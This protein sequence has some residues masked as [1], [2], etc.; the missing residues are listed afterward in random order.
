MSTQA[1]GTFKVASWTEKPVKETVGD[2]KITRASVI[3]SFEGAIEGE[4][5]VEYVM[6]H[7]ADKS[8]TFAGMLHIEGSI[9]G[10]TGSFV[11]QTTGTF[12]GKAARGTWSVVPGMGSGGLKDLNGMGGFDAPL[13]PD[14]TYTLHYNLS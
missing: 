7:R 14:G 11:L 9:G 2:G 1:K 6:A 5:T 13:G 8:A 3:Q 10:Q 4:G 12:D